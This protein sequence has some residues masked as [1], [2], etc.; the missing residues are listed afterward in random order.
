MRKS[1]KKLFVVVAMAFIGVFAKGQEVGIKTNLLYDATL[2]INLGV[3][4]RLAPKWS[5]D[6]SGDFNNWK[7]DDQSFKHWFVQPEARYWFCNT[8]AGHF[9]AVHGI[10]GRYNVGHLKHT[11]DF[12]GTDFSKLKDHRVEGYGL[13]AGVGYGYTWILGKHWNFEAEIGVGWIWTKFDTYECQGCGRKTSEDR[14]HNYFGPTK[15]AL[16][17]VYV[18]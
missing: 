14:T 4:F 15:A 17:L 3:E 6:I 11:F 10:G 12:L 18:F 8:M 9:L 5:L 2:S 13:G 16:N 7:I 1:L